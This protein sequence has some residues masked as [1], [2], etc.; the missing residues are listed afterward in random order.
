[1]SLPEHITW[2][3]PM[4]SAQRRLY[5][6]CQ[7]PGGDRA[8]HLLYLARLRGPFPLHMAQAF[9]ARMV[10][11][12]ET[13]R[14]AFRMEGG[15]FICEV[16]KEL[17]VEFTVVDGTG[18]D[19]E[20][21]LRAELEAL[22]EA[23]DK[24]FVLDAPPLFRVIIL[25]LAQDDCVLLFNCHHLIFDGY[26]GGILGQDIAHALAG[27][28]L[29][30]LERT[31]GDFVAWERGFFASKAY[32]EQR[33]F[34]CGQYRQAP[35]RLNFHP[36]QP[37]AAAKSFAGDYFIRHLDSG[38]LK[39]F[40]MSQGATPFMTLLAAFFCVLHRLTG[41]EEI[42]VGTL[43]SPREAGGFQNVIGLFANTL[44]LTQRPT[45]HTRFSDFLQSV[46]A[47]VF[48]AMQN[49][50]Y[51]FE[52]LVRQLPFLE[53][54]SRNPLFDVVF[55]FE[56]VA[57]RRVETF[58]GVSM[59]PLDLYAK[60]SMFDLAIDLVEYEDQVRFKVEFATAIF[61]EESLH[62]LMDA[63]FGIIEQ[64]CQRPEIPLGEL[65]ML[66]ARGRQRLLDWNDTAHPLKAGHTILQLWKRQLATSPDNPAVRGNGRQLT[67]ARLEERSNQL[68]HHLLGLGL[69]AGSVVAVALERTPE[70]VVAILALW[71]I[72]AVYLPLSAAHP[73][74]RLRHQL[75]DSQAALVLTQEHDRQRFAEFPNVLALE[76]LA[77]ATAACPRHDPG[78]QPQAD[79]PAY[80]IY[81]SGSTG[82]PK[83]V[84][85]EHKAL[86]AHIQALKGAYRLQPDDNVLQ[87]SSPT[88]DASL[89]QILVT[90]CAGACLV[91]P[92]SALPDPSALLEFL[93]EEEITVAEFPPAYLRELVPVL[94]PRSL[95]FL[96][97]LLSGGDVLSP[98]L[99]SR[100]QEHLPEQAL[101]LNFYGPTEATMAATVYAVPRDAA[102]HAD[103]A[104]LPIGKPLPNT[105]VHI[106]DASRNPL[107]PGIPGE[108]CI[109]GERLARGYLN[110]PELTA[111][112]FVS[113]PLHGREERVYRTGDRGR[114]LPDGTL[115][116]LGRLDR[117]VQLRGYRIELGE[118]EQALL[119]HPQVDDA[120]VILDRAETP[121]ATGEAAGEGAE[122]L[123]AFVAP[124]VGH[125]L[126][127][128]DL[129]AWL[130]QAL[131][132]YMLPSAFSFP[133]VL[134]R[135]AEGKLERQALA[136]A[137]RQ[138]V[139]QSAPAHDA[140]LDSCEWDLWRMWRRILGVPRI[141][142]S[143]VFFL[144]GGNSL[145]AIQ[146]MTEVKN[147]YGVDL[148][149]ALLLQ[150]PTIAS[151]AEYLRGASRQ[152]PGSCLVPLNTE[153]E[154]PVIVLIP[155]LGG[156]V[157]DLYEL[158]TQLDKSCPCHGLQS[159]WDTEAPGASDSVE[160]L[161]AYF[162]SQM[163]ARL[164]LERCVL[165]GH[166]F[167]GVVAYELS[168]Q[169]ERQGRAPLGLLLLDV[170]APQPVSQA[171]STSRA[172]ALTEQ[173]LLRLTLATLL[174]DEPPQPTEVAADEPDAYAQAL[175]ALQA[176][177]RVPQGIGVDTFRQHI[178]TIA[179]RARALACYAPETP[180]AL[181]IHLLR[182][183]EVDAA[184]G[185]TREDGGWTPFTTGGL[186]LHWVPGGHFSMIKAE[187]ATALADR[188]R[189][190]ITP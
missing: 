5:L 60:V 33:D 89:E 28:P 50:D 147:S 79:E 6:Q 44:P 93:A 152:A 29:P 141:G 39:A 161:A 181:G 168:R 114:W 97:R 157:L 96:R 42:T 158:S 175:M 150:A 64:V 151:L 110:Q 30:P 99:A 170:A 144:I 15:E 130:R 138:L 22:V 77:T 143:D 169:L 34:W 67:Y 122:R 52:H 80:I 126:A 127:A 63:Y 182:A 148:P 142:R 51:P 57:R 87:F 73:A 14:S 109:A 78:R 54:G 43:V 180:L 173:D 11:R 41:Q 65:C 16:H 35:K 183:R 107:P 111:E 74:K 84:L 19:P 4:S 140:P 166:S 133:G 108:L 1:M 155:G 46:R 121:E 160:S 178:G 76:A 104:S 119:S 139:G 56:R 102:P 184:Q 129:Y 162:L 171:D 164:P 101:L 12:H 190:C 116:F 134:P 189:Q 66:S 128:Q 18:I 163:Q 167:G 154:G 9:A 137:D 95:R 58:H 159:P 123:H 71:K 132:D 185:F 176:A 36:D 145:S 117:Q 40:S 23:H 172:T 120:A 113:L 62:G 32:G 83:G 48:Q 13:L 92:D 3:G 85:V 26:S 75:A 69:G 98:A 49:A 115:E 106:L 100:L 174:G 118:I 55:N 21:G 136:A 25:R 112:R 88:F 131:P 91:L 135:N 103:R 86:H 24:P 177:N 153:G 70:W 105:R 53:T 187:H 156:N 47:M 10:E 37:P 149:L 186:R 17:P 146:L 82:E 68:A 90:L 31:Y 38:A 179:R 2:R 72:G 125:A 7:L 94:A 165:V 124:R 61:R 59:E 45:A 188:I 8:Y 20:A 27:Q 81:T